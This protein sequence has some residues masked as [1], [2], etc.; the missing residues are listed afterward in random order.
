MEKKSLKTNRQ[1]T[2]IISTGR[3]E[4]LNYYKYLCQIIGSKEDVKMRRISSIIPE[5][6]QL[7]VTIKHAFLNPLPFAYFLNFL[8]YYHLQDFT[9]CR[10]YLQ[11]LESCMTNSDIFAIFPDTST[12][13]LVGIAEQLMGETFLAR[14]C[15][16]MADVADVHKITSAAKRLSSV[17]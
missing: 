12:V 5:E 8:C 16:Q 9:W 2:V 7:D 15:F 6:L 14:L 11:Q 1:K 10:H 3:C 17:I 4:S 13:I